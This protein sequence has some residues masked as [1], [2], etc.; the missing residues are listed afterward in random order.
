M[1][2]RVT[3][4]LTR[5]SVQGYLDLNSSSVQVEFKW[6]LR[7]NNKPH[8]FEFPTV[9]AELTHY[10]TKVWTRTSRVTWLLVP[11]NRPGLATWAQN[12]FFPSFLLYF[13]GY[14]NVWVSEGKNNNV[15]SRLT[16]ECVE[17]KANYI[18]SCGPH[19]IRRESTLRRK[20]TFQCVPRY[21]LWI[22]NYYT[23]SV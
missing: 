6:F 3:S 17:R 13:S 16:F 18:R 21:V 15:T 20:L 14:S 4:C 23:P 2:W 22:I 8:G 9:N 7:K 1:T 12:E 19:E 5:T 10:R 11:R